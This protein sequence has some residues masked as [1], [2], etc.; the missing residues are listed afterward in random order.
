M[1]R[2]RCVG[3]TV[4]ELIAVTGR[5]PPGTVSSASHE[6]NV[7]TG[8]HAIEFLLWGQDLNGTGPGAGVDMSRGGSGTCW[9]VE[10]MDSPMTLITFGEGRRIPAMGA[11]GARS[12]W[13]ACQS[14][15]DPTVS[16]RT[17]ERRVDQKAASASDRKSAADRAGPGRSAGRAS[18]PRSPP[19][20]HRGFS[21]AG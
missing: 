3:D 13:A 21:S 18:A 2:R 15:C 1:P 20:W 6:A 11:A 17:S 19:R 10:P 8:Y 5:A 14:S 4:T 7:A 9:E 16:A 12:S